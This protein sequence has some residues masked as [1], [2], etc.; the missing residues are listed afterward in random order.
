MKYILLLALIAG[1]AT[2]EWKKVCAKK[3]HPKGVKKV[4]GVFGP[5]CTCVGEQAKRAPG[6]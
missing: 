5:I 2:E 4:E 3:C 6:Y 1:C